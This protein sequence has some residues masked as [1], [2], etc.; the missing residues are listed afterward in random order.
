MIFDAG[1]SGPEEVSALLVG[2]EIPNDQLAGQLLSLFQ[3]IDTPDDRLRLFGVAGDSPVAPRLLAAIDQYIARGGRGYRP[4]ETI[5]GYL[6]LATIELTR[7][8][9]VTTTEQRRTAGSIRR[10]GEALCNRH[11]QQA[12]REGRFGPAEA[13]PTNPADCPVSSPSNDPDYAARCDYR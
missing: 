6:R 8:R 1:F 13:E 10:L 7:M 4:W 3:R 12:E 5:F 9:D 11:A 2:D